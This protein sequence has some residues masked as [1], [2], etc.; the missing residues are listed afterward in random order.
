MIPFKEKKRLQELAGIKT[1]VD[2]QTKSAVLDKSKEKVPYS[3]DLVK[4]AIEEG[5]EI[6]LLFQSQNEKY[7]MPVSKYRV[8]QPVILGSLKTGNRAIRGYQIFGQSEKEAK[9]TGVRSAE[10][11]NEWRLFKIDNIKSIF[12]TGRFFNEPPP[13][14]NPNDKQ[15]ASIDASFN[16]QRAKEAQEQIKQ[17]EEV[18]QAEEPDEPEE[19]EENSDEGEQEEEPQNN[20]NQEEPDNEEGEEE[21]EAA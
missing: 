15:F 10:A 11:E 12:F 18:D 2:F 16:S 7:K 4:Q 13:Q 21:K 14:Y 9:Q 20:Q 17:G 8:I 5:R 19:P 6:G 3:D 1:E